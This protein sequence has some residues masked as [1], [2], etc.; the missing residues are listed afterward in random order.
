MSKAKR[1][2]EM[3][4][5]VNRKRRFTVGELAKE[6]GVSKRTVLRDLQ[7]LGEMGVPL[8]SEVGPNGGY[9]VL[10]ERI[11]PPIAFSED[12]V[13]AIFF[14]IH[15]LKH[16]MS[17]PFDIEYESIKKK[18]YLNLS[19]DTR[20]SIDSIK[21][22]VDFL[23][24]YQQEEIPFLRQLLDAAIQQKVIKIYYETNGRRKGRSI[25][26][27]G[28]YANEGKWYCPSYCFLT[29]DYRV[30]RCD[31]MKSV[32]LDKEAKPVDLSNINLN[33]RF[34]ILK[35]NKETFELYVELTNKGVEKYRQIKWPNIQLNK[36]ED[37][38]GFLEGKI[39][40]TDVNFFSDF[41][42]SYGADANVK[43]PPELVEGIKER[44]NIILRQ[45]SN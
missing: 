23:Y 19:G 5:M 42:V 21:D 10:R 3:I 24:P 26:P 7:E 25:Q 9:Q 40:K 20:D 44:L 14:M 6:F 12:E 29:N 30:F 41:F 45:Y 15:A 16:F 8:Y 33:N 28:I 4:M 17:L 43:N 27:I 13:V 37:G 35:D 38:T 32:E 34:S 18:F 36:R 39:S 1:L 2:N 11:L 31:R 22:R